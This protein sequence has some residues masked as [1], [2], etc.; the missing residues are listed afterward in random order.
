MERGAQNGVVES[1]GF[2]ADGEVFE[3]GV[4][5]HGGVQGW[6]ERVARRGAN[7]RTIDRC[8]SSSNG[9]SISTKW[10]RSGKRDSWTSAMYSRKAAMRSC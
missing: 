10:Q 5:G 8:T 6:E 7:Q 2:L 3:T 9:A 4:L 1:G